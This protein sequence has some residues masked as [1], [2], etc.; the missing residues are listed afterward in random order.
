MRENEKCR[1]VVP[2]TSA[3]KSLHTLLNGWHSFITLLSCTQL[4]QC[5]L[6]PF[7]MQ[8]LTPSCWA[9]QDSRPSKGLKNCLETETQEFVLN[10][11]IHG[12]LYFKWQQLWES[13]EGRSELN[14]CEESR[15]AQLKRCVMRV[16]STWKKKR[17]KKCLLFSQTPASLGSDY[18]KKKKRCSVIFIKVTCFSSSLVQ[19][20]NSNWTL[21]KLHCRDRLNTTSQR[22]TYI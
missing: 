10:G 6:A 21:D 1:N 19:L 9:R 5:Q 22:F 18:Q 2:F 20:S 7:P 16:S 8:I 17:K 14:V 12:F 3:H 11:P 13:V 15:P 4:C